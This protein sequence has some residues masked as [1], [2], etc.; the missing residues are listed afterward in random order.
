MNRLA[1]SDGTTLCPVLT[2]QR[3]REQTKIVSRL[4]DGS[5]HVQT[6]GAAGT[7]YSVQVWATAAQHDA[8]DDAEALTAEV[9]LHYNGAQIIGYIDSAV[10]WSEAVAGSSYTGTLTLLVTG[11]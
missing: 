8:L 6:V 3:G 11:V 10:S 4:Y 7:K 2:C 9:V 1:L 5:Y